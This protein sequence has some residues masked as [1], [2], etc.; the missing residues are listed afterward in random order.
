MPRD[1]FFVPLVPVSFRYIIR[2]YRKKTNR[3]FDVY[4]QG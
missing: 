4:S 2:A 1:T 3:D